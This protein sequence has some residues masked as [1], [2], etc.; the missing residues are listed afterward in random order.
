MSR[1]KNL[2]KKI[3]F[4]F[5]PEQIGNIGRKSNRR[6]SSS[7]TEAI[8]RIAAIE[9]L[10]EAVAADQ[11]VSNVEKLVDDLCEKL[12][13]IERQPNSVDES[14]FT[15]STEIETMKRVSLD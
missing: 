12:R 6:F 13:E 3:L 4:F 10:T 1:F 14:Q 7:D 2:T 11:Q 15:D 8:K 9:S 5:L